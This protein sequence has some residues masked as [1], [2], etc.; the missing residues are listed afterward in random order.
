MGAVSTP[1]YYLTIPKLLFHVKRTISGGINMNVLHG[2]PYSGNYPSTT[3]PGYITFSYQFTDMWN[4]IQP[5]WQHMK[6]M[7]DYT[8]RIFWIL[9][10]GVSKIDPALYLFVNPWV[11]LHQYPSMNLEGLGYTYDYLGAA[12]SL[13]PSALV[14]NGIMAPSGPSYKALVFASNV[15]V[16]GTQEEIITVD[17]VQSVT[18]LT[19]PLSSSAQLLTRHCRLLRSKK[20]YLNRQ[21]RK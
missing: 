17:A 6:D 10:Q 16:T 20:S 3:W 11:D 13:S 15:F 19:R 21:Y 9:Q 7:M 14:K 2:S 4:S 8:R 5:C 1:A 12:S 18:S